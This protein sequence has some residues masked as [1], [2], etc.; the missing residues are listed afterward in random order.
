MSYLKK[1][2]FLAL[3]ATVASMGLAYGMQGQ[4]HGDDGLDTG[5]A[6]VAAKPPAA[7]DLSTDEGQPQPQ[8]SAAAQPAVQSAAAAPSA[9]AALEEQLR[10]VRLQQQI[11]EAQASA[12]EAKA[13]EAEALRKEKEAN[14]KAAAAAQ[15]QPAAPA[16][17][18]AASAAAAS[19]QP[20]QAFS[21][22][23]AALVGGR[24]PARVA[25]NIQTETARFGEG[26]GN[27]LTKGKWK[28]KK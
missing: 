28:V 22:P 23:V 10:M 5:S 4:P 1:I 9:M 2:N 27:L 8:P 25:H 13:R 6:H 21:A 12:A 15:P 11:A 19:A 26:L 3:L 20:P 24:T 7:A 14:A 16:S 17:A 18:A